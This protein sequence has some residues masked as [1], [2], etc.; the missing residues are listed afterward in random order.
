MAVRLARVGAST[1]VELIASD[2]LPVLCTAHTKQSIT[3]NQRLRELRDTRAR[4]LRVPVADT[5]TQDS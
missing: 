1:E 5:H 4:V 3:D 2:V